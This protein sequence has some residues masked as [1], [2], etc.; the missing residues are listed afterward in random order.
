MLKG[1][2]NR[3][4]LLLLSISMGLVL[5]SACDRFPVYNVR[6]TNESSTEVL[7]VLATSTDVAGEPSPVYSLP[8]DRVPRKN[9]DLLA[10]LN[11]TGEVIFLTADCVILERVPVMEGSYEFRIIEGGSVQVAVLNQPI[12]HGP[13]FLEETA[14]RCRIP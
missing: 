10:V 2:L 3:T 5:T 14:R 6:I 7:I 11:N 8:P 1:L 9:P 13:P 4:V 12:P